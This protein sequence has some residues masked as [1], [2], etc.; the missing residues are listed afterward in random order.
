MLWELVKPLKA[1]LYPYFAYARIIK[2]VCLLNVIPIF[3]LWILFSILFLGK[4][5]TKSDPNEHLQIVQDPDYRRFGCT[6][7][8][9][10]AL[11]TFIPHR[12]CIIDYKLK[13]Q[14]KLSLQNQI[15]KILLRDGKN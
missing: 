5:S 10:I 4:V 8:M 11:A 9:N 15:S 12:Y 1:F 13:S 3:T 7:D 2:V 6:V 14:V